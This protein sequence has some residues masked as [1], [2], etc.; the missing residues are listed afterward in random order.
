MDY[1]FDDVVGSAEIFSQVVRD[2]FDDI[3]V[4]KCHLDEVLKIPG[5][6]L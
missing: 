1:Y 2:L 4:Y 6:V 3:K 5:Q